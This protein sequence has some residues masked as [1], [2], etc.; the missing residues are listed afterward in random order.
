MHID[1]RTPNTKLSRAHSLEIAQRLRTTF[2]KLA[3][4][5]VRIV[6]RVSETSRSGPALRECMVEVHLPSGQVATVSE[7][8]RKLGALLRRATERSWKTVNALVGPPP[9]V[10]KPIRVQLRNKGQ[11]A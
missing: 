5:I 1:V 2:A 11:Q 7:R 6:V 10:S 4:K 3:H 9:D 8:Q